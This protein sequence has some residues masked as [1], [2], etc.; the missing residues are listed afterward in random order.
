MCGGTVSQREDDTEEAI[1]RRLET[2]EREMLPIVQ[3]YRRAR[4]L[5]VD[6]GVGPGA[7]GQARRRG[8]GLEGRPSG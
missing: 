7:E 3:Y 8:G 6:D 4:R 5:I 1:E 2:Y